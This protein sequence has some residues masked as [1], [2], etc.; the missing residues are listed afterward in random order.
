MI[1]PFGDAALLVT[2]GEVIDPVLNAR[3]HALAA[4]VRSAD[5][6]SAWGPPVVGYAS[7]VVPY[8]SLTISLDEARARLGELVAGASDQAEPPADGSS[9]QAERVEIPVR[10]GGANGPDLAEVVERTG[11]TPEQVVEAHSSTVYRVYLLGFVP[12]FAYLGRL[13]AELRVPRRDEPRLRVP[14]GSVAIAD[15]QTAVYP[16]ETPGGW[17]ILGRTD[18]VMWDIGRER[19]ALLQPGQ[20]VRFVPVPES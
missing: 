18:A 15:L 13:P 11:L 14:S 7:V 2:L 17:H 1:E 5:A 20:E 19:P 4:R 6:A 8:P 16:S 12:G 3:A 10:Y 9:S